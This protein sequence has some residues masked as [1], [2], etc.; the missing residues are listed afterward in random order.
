MSPNHLLAGDRL[1]SDRPALQN[2]SIKSTAGSCRF[3]KTP[4]FL[5]HV[6]PAKLGI[7]LLSSRCWDLTKAQ[8][9][10]QHFS[11]ACVAPFQHNTV[12]C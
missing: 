7:V 10:A 8:E 2:G 6:K 4:A 1:E 3:S 12:D 11:C 5:S 9:P